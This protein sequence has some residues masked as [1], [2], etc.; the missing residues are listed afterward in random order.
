MLGELHCI[1]RG[2][3][4][5]GRRTPAHFSGDIEKSDSGLIGVWPGCYWA[6]P[7]PAY[8]I[9]ASASRREE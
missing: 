7:N 1:W 6:R 2:A 5:P 4:T 3:E 9:S 8:Q